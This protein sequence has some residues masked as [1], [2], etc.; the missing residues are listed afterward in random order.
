MA[1]K[2]QRNANFA[3]LSEMVKRMS[4]QAVTP[5]VVI[6]HPKRKVLV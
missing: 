2:K 3:R 4:I 5:V 6:E 1:N